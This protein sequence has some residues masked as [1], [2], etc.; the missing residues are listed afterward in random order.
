MQEQV[1]QFVDFYRAGLRTAADLAKTSLESAERLQQQQL[2]M[3]RGA[4]EESEKSTNELAGVKNVDELMAL[5]TRLAGSQ[6]ERAMEF[7]SG[8]WRTASDNQAAMMGQLRSQLSQ[9]TT[10]LREA[11]SQQEKRRATG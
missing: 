6:W 3:L 7:W 5:Q 4:I 8:I 2:K 10:S 11:S 9:T 1:T